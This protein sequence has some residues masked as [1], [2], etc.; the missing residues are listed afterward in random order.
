MQHKNRTASKPYA[1]RGCTV[2]TV[3]SERSAL[4]EKIA[5]DCYLQKEDER[6]AEDELQMLCLMAEKLHGNKCACAAAERCQNQQHYFR[7]TP[8]VQ[9]GEGFICTINGKSDAVN[10]NQIIIEKIMHGEA[11]RFLLL[12]CLRILLQQ[13]GDIRQGSD[14]AL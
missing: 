9:P 8:A 10:E 5:D 7:H 1:A 6:Y 13:L 2:C 3:F 12:I 4:I 14:A 11:P